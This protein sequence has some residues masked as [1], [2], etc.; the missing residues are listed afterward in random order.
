MSKI[1][2][3]I[4]KQAEN[5]EYSPQAFTDKEEIPVFALVPKANIRYFLF[6]CLFVNVRLSLFVNVLF[7]YQNTNEYK[8]M[9]E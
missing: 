8:T 9:E 2:D 3:N 6:V 5:N 4:Y 7:T 1:N